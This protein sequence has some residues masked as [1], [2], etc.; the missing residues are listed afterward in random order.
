MDA[1]PIDLD[2]IWT[3]IFDA[4][5]SP[6][7]KSL[8]FAVSRSAQG[9]LDVPRCS[10]IVD[11]NIVE[12]FRFR[13]WL[14]DGERGSKEVAIHSHQHFAQSWILAGKGTDR[15]YSVEAVHDINEATHAEYV[16]RW[17]DDEETTSAYQTHQQTLTVFNTG[18]LRKLAHVSSEEHG[19]D[20]SSAVASG[21]YHFRDVKPESSHASLVFSDSSRGFSQEAGVAGPI[22]G[23]EITQICN[24]AGATAKALAQF[25]DALR[26]MSPDELDRKSLEATYWTFFHACSLAEAGEMKAALRLFNSPPESS[27]LLHFCDRKKEIL[28]SDG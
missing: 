27:P 16:P 22:D 20:T 11:G 14:P 2:I 18:G 24:P 15:R 6:P 4:L 3:L 19:K 1:L 23:T 7:S 13:V 12:L 5:T 28:T 10:I 21:R 25:T 26:S 9:L 8:V 17:H